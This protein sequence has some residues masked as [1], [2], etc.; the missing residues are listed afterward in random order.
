MTT[1]KDKA[2]AIRDVI[3]LEIDKDNLDELTGKVNKLVNLMGLSAEIKASAIKRLKDAELIAYAKHKGEKLSPNI[4]KLVI[5]GETSN[6]KANLEYTDRLNA[7]IVH[8]LDGL[9]TIISLKK[10]ELDK[11]I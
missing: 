11:S 5:E 3:E 9:R 8:G 6:E 4:M 7:G 10:T 1:E 2:R